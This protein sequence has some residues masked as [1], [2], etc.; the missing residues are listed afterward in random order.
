MEKGQD[1]TPKGRELTGPQSAFLEAFARM[2]CVSYACEAAGIGRTCYYR[3]REESEAFRAA[4]EIAK[5]QA[6]DALEREARRRALDGVRRLKF[7]RGQVVM[8]PCEPGD[9]DGQKVADA[10]PDR[11]TP[12]QWAKPYVEHEYSD[13]L[14]EFILKAARPEK[15]RERVETKVSG[16]VEHEHTGGVTV[17]LPDNGRSAGNRISGVVGR[18]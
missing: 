12:E 4:A 3:W 17:Y 1:G 16:K 18:N 8:I 7:D 9:P 10:D 2:G 15:Y 14:L 13:R 11:G 6:I 5:E